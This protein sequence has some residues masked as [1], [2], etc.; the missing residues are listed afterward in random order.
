MSELTITTAMPLSTA[1]FTSGAAACSSCVLRTMAATPWLM[2]SW[3]IPIWPLMSAPD[4]G[5]SMKVSTPFCF[6][7]AFRPSPIAM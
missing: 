3:I 6:A 7:S 2:T 5:A 1:C 4:W